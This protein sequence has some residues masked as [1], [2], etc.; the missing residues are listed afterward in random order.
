MIEKMNT[1]NLVRLNITIRMK[2]L[3]I[4]QTN[5]SERTGISCA[6]ISRLIGGYR[7]F[8]EELL[9]KIATAL[10]CDVQDLYE[11]NLRKMCEKDGT[12]EDVALYEYLANNSKFISSLR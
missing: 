11:A 8:N 4:N 9:E 1:S 12:P 10:E 5:L 2:L 6:Y 7:R 3:G